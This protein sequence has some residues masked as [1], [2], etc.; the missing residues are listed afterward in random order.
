MP[1]MRRVCILPGE[2]KSL[3]RNPAV[4]RGFYQ[5]TLSFVMLQH[6]IGHFEFNCWNNPVCDEFIAWCE[7]RGV[8]LYQEEDLLPLTNLA[9]EASQEVLLEMK[10]RWH[11]SD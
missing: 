2:F 8:T 1:I 10:M 4:L 6:G 7:E 3:L 9:G 5:Y 11:R